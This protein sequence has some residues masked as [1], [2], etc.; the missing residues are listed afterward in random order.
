[1]GD[2]QGS[3]CTSLGVQAALCI[4]HGDRGGTTQSCVL[5]KG[6]RQG[7]VLP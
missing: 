4:A 7:L 2:M 5:H 6:A 1:M 3:L